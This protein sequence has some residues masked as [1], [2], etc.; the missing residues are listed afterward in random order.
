MSHRGLCWGG[1]GGMLSAN[2]AHGRLG[3][4]WRE[5]PRGGGCC[6]ESESLLPAKPFALVRCRRG[7][8]AGDGQLVSVLGAGKGLCV[9]IG[10]ARAA[11][12]QLNIS[13][14]AGAA[15]APE[16]EAESPQCCVTL[17]QPRHSSPRCHRS[18]LEK[19]GPCEAALPNVGIGCC[20]LRM[21]RLSSSEGGMVPGGSEVWVSPRGDAGGTAWFTFP[22]GMLAAGFPPR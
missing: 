9:S 13:G 20:R 18:S 17:R 16:R 10:R 22:L 11:W 7:R 5:M 14:W 1:V 2:A 4:R 15:F 8:S 19:P 6:R 3:K 12:L 21:P